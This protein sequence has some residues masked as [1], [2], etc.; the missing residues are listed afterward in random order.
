MGQR[1]Q[2]GKHKEK[3]RKSKNTASTTR[4][5]AP[6]VS[7]T[8][9]KHGRHDTNLASTRLPGRDHVSQSPS[10]KAKRLPRRKSE[11]ASLSSSNKKNHRSC[12][13]KSEDVL[14]SLSAA[15]DDRPSQNG[16]QL[17]STA[18]LQRTSLDAI[19]TAIGLLDKHAFPLSRAA[20]AVGRSEESLPEL[21][22]LSLA[23]L[24]SLGSSLSTLIHLLREIHTRAYPQDS[25]L[26][27]E[28]RSACSEAIL[29][30]AVSHAT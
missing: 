3:R 28:M 26:A 30:K 27:G 18:Y 13:M 1:R 9:R 14:D 8:N 11:Y 19:K 7:G 5:L 29:S 4:R 6:E 2:S 25:N 15:A 22:E 23:D 10:S 12:K 20:M 16:R 17:S 21:S 24:R